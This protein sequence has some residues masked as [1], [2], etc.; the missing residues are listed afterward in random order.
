MLPVFPGPQ[1]PLDSGTLTLLGLC[2]LG[3]GFGVRSVQ[4]ARLGASPA[5]AVPGLLGVVVHLV[6]IGAVV[7]WASGLRW[8]PNVR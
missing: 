8:G 6:V 3:A 7:A 2:L 5:D 4:R 1:W